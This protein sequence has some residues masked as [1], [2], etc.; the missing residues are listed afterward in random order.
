MNILDDSVGKITAFSAES[1][2]SAARLKGFLASTGLKRSRV[3][4]RGRKPSTAEIGEA[5]KAVTAIVEPVLTRTEHLT[6]E[7]A[8]TLRLQEIME[9]SVTTWRIILSVLNFQR[10]LIAQTRRACRLHLPDLWTE[11]WERRY[12]VASD[13]IEDFMETIAL[14]LNEEFQAELVARAKAIP[15]LGLGSQE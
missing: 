6:R 9:I 13:E 1:S 11:E 10:R 3:R 5:I 4:G 7:V 2:E 12:A 8:M 15:E 14:G